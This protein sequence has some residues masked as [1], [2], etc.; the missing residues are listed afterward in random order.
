MEL[1]SP[2][3]VRT[4]ASI[5]ERQRTPLTR[6]QR[7]PF[8][9]LVVGGGSHPDYP[10]LSPGDLALDLSAQACPDVIGSIFS[11]PFAPSSF[12]EVVFEW[13]PVSVATSGRALAEARRILRPGGQLTIIARASG[14]V[15]EFE[16][17]C[18]GFVGMTTER[19]ARDDVGEYVVIRS[20]TPLLP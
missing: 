12:A 1:A 7:R 19:H 4:S 17:E 10:R 15:L 2:S 5:G 18:A 16:L 9:R 20:R 11:S 13:L 3:A 8:R 6:S 14:P